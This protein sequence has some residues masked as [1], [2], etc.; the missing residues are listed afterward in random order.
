MLK[1]PVLASIPLIVIIFLSA[2]ASFGEPILG[3][4]HIS[5]NFSINYTDDFNDKPLHAVTGSAVE[6]FAD[7]LEDIR[8]KEL[9]YNFDN[10]HMGIVKVYDLEGINALGGYWGMTFDPYFLGQVNPDSGHSATLVEQYAIALHEYFHVIQYHYFIDSAYVRDWIK[11]GNARLLQDKLYDFTDENGDHLMSYYGEANGYLATAGQRLFD[12]SY[13]ACL[14]WNYVTEQFGSIR[15]EPDI[16][17]DVLQKLWETAEHTEGEWRDE[18]KVFNNLMDSLGYGNHELKDIYANFAV[19]NYLKDI[20][21]NT[22]DMYKYIDELQPLP[23]KYREVLLWKN[24]TLDVQDTLLGTDLYLSGYATRYYQVYFEPA[25][26]PSPTTSYPVSVEVHQMTRND[27]IFHVITIEKDGSIDVR[28]FEGKDLDT[29]VAVH[30]GARI[31]LIVSNLGGDIIPAKYRYFI[32]CHESTSLKILS[33]RFYPD[34]SLARAGLHDDPEKMLAVIE[35][36][37]DGAA[38][39]TGLS[40]ED[41]RVQIGTKE[42]TISSLTHVAGLYFMEIMPPEQPSDTKYDLT[43]AYGSVSDTEPNSVLYSDIVSDTVTVIDVSGSMDYS[44]KIDA[45]KVASQVFLNSAH[46]DDLFG[47]VYFD[48]DAGY[49]AEGLFNVGVNRAVLLDNISSLVTSPGG[50]SIGDGMFVANNFL[51]SYGD[52]LHLKYMIILSDGDENK[53]KYID[54]VA[55]LLLTDPNN[56]ICHAVFIGQDAEIEALEPVVRNSSGISLFAFENATPPSPSPLGGLYDYYR[57]YLYG[58]TDSSSSETDYPITSEL[59]NLY[60]IIAEEI[61][62]EER[63][64]ANRHTYLTGPWNLAETIY[65]EEAE[66]ASIVLSFRATE[67][68]NLASINLVLPNGTSIGASFSYVQGG[69]DRQFFGHLLWKIPQLKAGNYVITYNNGNGLF[70]YFCEAAIRSPVTMNVYY[71]LPGYVPQ[72]EKNFRVTGCEFPIIATISGETAPVTGADVWAT[73][74]TGVFSGEQQWNVKL[75]DDGNHGDSLANDGV[76]A[77]NFTRTAWPGMYHVVIKATGKTSWGDRYTRIKEGAFSLVADQDQDGDGLPENWEVRHDLDD[78]DSSGD[79]GPAGDPDNDGISNKEELLEGIYPRYYD[80]DFGGESDWSEIINDRD[81][82]YYEDDNLFPPAIHATPGN[83]NAT[84]YYSNSSAYAFIKLYRSLALDTGYTLIVSGLD[85]DISHYNDTGLTNNANYYYRA[86]AVGHTGELSRLSEPVKVTP[87]LDPINPKGWV[88]INGGVNC[89]NSHIVD[90]ILWAD[91]DVTEMKISQDASFSGV[92]W[93]PFTSTVSYTLGG[94]GLQL[95]YVMFR[96]ASGNIGGHDSGDYAYDGIIVDPNYVPP[97]TSS[98]STT[99]E[100][101]TTPVST[102]NDF[103]FALGGFLAIALAVK[104][105]KRRKNY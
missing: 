13:A 30:P 96:D 71:P 31:A 29:A 55:P 24:E 101:S 65:L 74:S 17:V 41:F 90:L 16:G 56:T 18:V 44:S 91:E 20:P 22:Y 60:R 39:I 62:R 102:R 105:Q 66:S 28:K 25:D 19:A 52:P 8:A 45:A 94:Y 68:P 35:L 32:N 67:A 6:A 1:K 79:N 86:Q 34:S 61:T 82:Y 33:P 51:Y 69:S 50:T 80:T 76:Y 5:S 57:E 23:G 40:R 77:N 99:T 2:T 103:I 58:V 46:E 59:T 12:A 98:P 75:Y 64:Y 63:V 70:E 87:K 3:H 73:V 15:T 49:F 84:I 9:S 95:V 78:K 85:P 100:E 48:E 104:K 72:L 97:T 89:T 42:A 4:F 10:P 38:P 81:P 37:G 54:S 47:I 43:V 7:I 26:P 21:S 93:Q 27:M 88:Q 36:I 83:Q 53:P 11:E 92:A 14:F